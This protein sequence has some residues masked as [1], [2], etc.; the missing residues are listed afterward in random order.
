[1]KKR[2]ALYCFY[3]DKGIVRDFVL[4]YLK[5]LRK[6]CGDIWVV[7]NCEL[8]SVS[9]KKLKAL[10]V[11]VF[12][13]ENSGFDVMAWKE[14][15]EKIGWDNLIFYD[16]L[17]ICN[18]TCYGPVYP[19]EEM[20]SKMENKECDFWG[21]VKHP[22]QPTYLL[23]NKQGYV[24]EH[25]MSYFIVVRNRLLSSQDFKDYWDYMPPIITKSDAVGNN[26]TFFTKHFEDLGYISDSYVD[27]S[28]Y[29]GRCY[30][31]SIILAN[32]LLIKDRC[33]L[34]KRRAFFFPEYGALLDVSDTSQTVELMKYLKDNTDYNT[35]LIWDDILHTQKLSRLNTN[36]HFGKVLPSETEYKRTIEKACILI[37]LPEMLHADILMPYMQTLKKCYKV[38]ILYSDN[39][40]GVYAMNI[41][42]DYLKDDDFER[43]SISSGRVS[44][45]CLPVVL[46]EAKNV[47]YVACLFN[48][49]ALEQ[50][51][52]I[53]K[54]HYIKNIY[55]SMISSYKYIVNII[56]TFEKNSRLGALFPAKID[57]GSYYGIN[58]SRSKKNTANNK[59]IYEELN[60]DVP[61]DDEPFTNGD[62]VFW[63]R[64]SLL[65][66]F[67]DYL[68]ENKSVLFK[69]NSF[70]YFL[71]MIIQ[72]LGYYSTTVT[73]T[74][75]AA[76]YIDQN[77]YYKNTL[78][79]RFYNVFGNIGWSFQSNVG[80]IKTKEIY[81]KIYI[82]PDRKEILETH[83]SFRELLMLIK[84]YPEHRKEFL[85]N[86]K[87]AQT[88]EPPIYTYL[89]YVSVE[90]GRLLLYFMSGRDLSE[91]YVKV[92]DKKYYSKKEL[93]EGQSEVGKYVKEY[94]N[95]YAGF[96][97]IPIDIVKD[98]LLELFNAKDEKIYFKW[99]SG[100]SFNALELNSLG[101]YSRVTKEG[102]AIQSR[103]N[104]YKAVCSS[105][106][107]SF[108]DKML[109]RYLYFN[110]RHNVTLMSENLG[111]ADNTFQLFKYCVDK[112]EN[113]YYI[114]SEK[115][116]ETEKDMK[117][118]KRMVIHNSKKHKKLMAHSKQWIG[119]FS[120]RGELFVTD[121]CYKD[122]HYNMLPAKWI[123]VPHGMA[124]GDKLVA[125]LYKYAWDNPSM[126]FAGSN[127]EAETYADMYSFKN[128][129]CLGSPRMDKW[130][131]SVI[132]DKEIFVFFT[133]RLGMSKGRNSF[134]KS[135]EESDYFITIKNIIIALREE[136]P[137]Y[138]IN[139]AFHHE[140]V[141]QGYDEKI[142]AA[143]N[144]YRIN[145]IYLNS[146][147]GAEEFNRH[148]ASA[149]YLITDFSSVA[150]DF[151]YKDDAIAIYYLQE[152][153]I[154]YHYELEDKF[155]DIQLGVVTRSIKELK[156]ALSMKSPTEEMMKRKKKFF[157][158]LDDK[159]CE[160]VYEEIF[161][162]AQ[163]AKLLNCSE[164]GNFKVSNNRL[165]VY[166]LYDKDGIVDD[167]IIYYLKELRRFCRE[168]C[169]VVNGN[170]CDNGK[171]ALEEVSDKVLIREN[172]GF[173]SWAY[174]TAI[175]SYGYDYLAEEFD[176]LILNNFTNFGPINSFDNM[177][178]I[179]DGRDCD[180]WGITRY[181]A[182]K[183]QMFIDVPMVDHLQSYFTAIRKPMLKSPY[184]RKYWKTLK[185]PD[186]YFDAVKFHELRFTQYFEK[187]G[188]VSSE[189]IPVNAYS[190][191]CH[192]TAVRM[193]FSQIQ[194]YKSPFLKRKIFSAKDGMY[195][196]P[197]EEEKNIPELVE[198]VKANT[199]YD[200]D[201]IYS[202]IKRTFNLTQDTSKDKADELMAQYQK[203]IKSA[204]NEADVR[205]ANGLRNKIFNIEELE[206]SFNK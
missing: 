41:M 91:C 178:D 69:T 106:E 81:K 118:K 101:L 1:M 28:K 5:E 80:N 120:L 117:Y 20:F 94:S 202:N 199:S 31:S 134:Y 86:K 34:V 112:G 93:N 115:V 2:V 171:R 126:T 45:G 186:D 151:S 166:F 173:D 97:E 132:D 125:M 59:S 152:D 174:K 25:I 48:Y 158:A 139:Y 4:F 96:F 38:K 160:R 52:K 153:F 51:N 108:K 164:Q 119:S 180:F 61:F 121:G 109:F 131:N 56:Y 181:K 192:N 76:L 43:V 176:E 50:A 21:A 110:K 64:K 7:A 9:R 26:E 44:L 62:G 46:K 188:Y 65:E 85:E 191:K 162:N 67:F 203:L 170:I 27:L 15:M 130:K 204:E 144:E 172:K 68:N 32:D 66:D 122:I 79:N 161:C 58:K 143:L 155:F 154:K 55:D 205:K 156:A 194:K 29:K 167:Y 12:E 128:V 190:D 99:A 159:N 107:Y 136:F 183:N 16:E 138:K 163:K 140:V 95:A 133:W 19:F 60:L 145:W 83:F 17:I 185:C 114:V 189:F 3:D 123:F 82:H 89:R 179:M 177:F 71:P 150:Y 141:K 54:E 127:A 63:I 102:Y 10:G 87:T 201:L 42:K 57:F 18:Y 11:H 105:K 197:L 37:Y 147:E 182:E 13:R 8:T 40:V 73:T 49:G 142:K 22:E 100:I 116:F 78:L 135:F 184:F 98:E 74:E 113:V 84:K 88:A 36:M 47:Q 103:E 168:I 129:T 149:K 33:P 77:N 53:S 70:E 137:E 104:F 193:A 165:A 157:Y 200:T 23:P 169:V 35:E 124:V 187:L 148:F 6:V 14:T 39:S 24:Y 198:Y 146:I 72:N 196:F 206:H 30:N 195:E 111:A 90:R 75:N 92:K 175:E